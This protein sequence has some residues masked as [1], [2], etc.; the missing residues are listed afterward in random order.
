MEAEPNQAVYWQRGGFEDPLD[1][2]GG[3]ETA[4]TVVVGGGIAGLL[5][6]ERLRRGGRRVIVLE[7]QRCGAGA[8]GRSSGF[9]T[10]DS[11]LELADLV[12]DRGDECA[13]TLW[14]FAVSGVRAIEQT[15][16]HYGI[17]CEL[18]RLD[19]VL[20][21]NS[22]RGLRKVGD[23]HAARRKLGYD[24][25]L[26]ESGDVKSVIGSAWSRGAVRYGGTFGIN[27]YAF[28][29]GLAGALREQSVRIHERTPVHDVLAGEVRAGAF[30]VKA[31][32][33]VV[34]TD[35]SLPELRLAEEDIYRAQTFLAIT[36]PL[37]DGTMR[38]L[39]PEGPVMVWDTD[40][41]Y[42]Y[43]R[44]TAGGRLLMGASSAAQTYSRG[45]QRTPAAIL[46]KMRAYLGRHFPWLTVEFECTWPG[47]IGVTRDFVPLAATDPSR[48]G[49]HFIGGAAGLPWAA[50]LGR[51]TADRI[52][53]RPQAAEQ[54]FRRSNS[55]IFRCAARGLGK[56]A[57]F[58]LSH[59]AV[60]CLR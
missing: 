36:P 30:R 59:A 17:D 1:P 52:L 15:V 58:A 51:L 7:R 21:A 28:C 46:R 38:R 19:S 54:F 33:I 55:A 56:P 47:L 44:P 53:G 48:P 4:D 16:Q 23:E 8:S 6:A 14:E 27:P 40:L 35:R 9:L 57:A 20:L 13:R 26:F 49:V 12:R 2:L 50:A 22:V 39:F 45:R 10:P 37:P 11:E 3:D 29:R 42:Q 32:H 24:S 43:F 18:A 25:R 41:I 5:C 60:K 34:C 31:D